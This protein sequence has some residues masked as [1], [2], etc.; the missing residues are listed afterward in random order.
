MRLAA[1]AVVLV[2]GNWSSAFGR[3]IFVNNVLGDDRRGGTMA[4]VGG[5]GTG[6]CRS[7][8]KALRIACP[9]DH[10]IVANTGQPYREG[11]TVQGPRHSGLDRFPTV[12]SGNG[13]TLDGSM[14]LFENVWEF[15]GDGMFRTRPI[16][17]SFQQLFLAGA[18]LVR[19]QPLPG[20]FPKLGPR[21][22]CLFRGW[23]Y[24]AVDAGRLPEDY[25]LTCCGEQVGITLYNVHDVIIEDL[26][27]RGFWLDGVNCHDNVMR[28]DLIRV[29]A[30]E[31]GRSGF[32]VG[33]WSRVRI[34]TS[35]AAGNAAAQVRLEG[36]CQVQLLDNALDEATAPAIVREGG[37]IV[38]GE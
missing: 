26:N 20:E 31:N 21:E 11:I 35:T 4:E 1:V 19:K 16:S 13:A 37:T 28:A 30:R 15:A 2:L 34:D 5:E 27:V 33:G 38:G 24:F 29:S 23:I 3:D 9:G 17:K 10:I 8:A 6:P 25:D 14:S 36:V 12:I 7:I 22:W 32:S 18:P